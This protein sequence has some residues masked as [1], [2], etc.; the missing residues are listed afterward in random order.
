[1]SNSDYFT[2]KDPYD[3]DKIPA[4]FEKHCKVPLNKEVY[5]TYRGYC[6]RE[7]AVNR[8]LLCLFCEHRKMLDIPAMIKKE[9][10]K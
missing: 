10:E 9:L 1:M 7:R 2:S 6:E 4:S 3:D 5:C 8:E